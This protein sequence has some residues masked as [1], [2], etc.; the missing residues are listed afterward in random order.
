MSSLSR[1]STG[2][3]LVNPPVRAYVAAYG[4]WFLTFLVGLVVAFAV[5][6]V[7]QMAMVF[8]PLDRYGVHLF[9]QISV[10]VLVVLLLALVVVTEAYYR[11][12]VPR[13]QVG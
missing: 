5:R 4:L 12:G 10:V 11:N 7:F 13:R 1:P 2:Q 6:D 8:T 3:D 9:N